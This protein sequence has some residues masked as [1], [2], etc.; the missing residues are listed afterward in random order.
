MISDAAAKGLKSEHLYDL[1]K[2]LDSRMQANPGRFTTYGTKY[3]CRTSLIEPP[4]G[5][6]WV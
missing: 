3:K 2:T 6:A 5:P 4:D 1:S